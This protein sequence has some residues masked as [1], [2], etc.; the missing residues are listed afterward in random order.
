[1]IRQARIRAIGGKVLAVSVLATGF[2]IGVA[3]QA[4]V[5]SGGVSLYVAS[6]GSGSS[7]TSTAPCGSIGA[8]LAVATPGSTIH[9]G[10]GT[11]TEQDQ[12]TVSNVKI[13]GAGP[14]KTIIQP[15]SSGLVS[16]TDTDSGNPQF[17]T[18]DVAPGT[19]GVTLEKLGVDDANAISF[20][21]SDGDGCAQDPVGIYYHDA[22]GTIDD[23]AVTGVD[24][25]ADLAGCQGG[26]GIYVA[27]NS[28]STSTVTMKKVSEPTATGASFS[29][30][31]LPAY[32]KNGITCDDPGTTC[33]ITK[34]TVEGMGPTGVIAQNGIQVFGASATVEKNKVSG[35]TYTLGGNGN[36]ATG[37]LVLNAGT[38][39]VSQNQAFSSDI[40]IYG[41]LVPSYGLMPPTIGAWSFAGNAAT[42]ATDTGFP[43]SRLYGEGIEID[44]TTNNVT[45]SG[46][47]AE[48]NNYSGIMLL[49]ATGAVVSNNTVEDNYVGL[50]LGAPGSAI[51]PSTDNTV[52]GNTIESNYTFGVL[53][54]GKYD[55]GAPLSTGANSGAASDNTFGGNTWSGNSVAQAADFS[56]S[57]GSSPAPITNTWGSPTADSCE[58]TAGGDPTGLGSAYY[59]C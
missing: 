45:V 31:K 39:T 15:P 13:K 22:S 30:P 8:A 43:S 59:A 44:S 14:T 10:A 32:D 28:G 55:P 33:T 24:M 48:G 49:G 50:Y 2:G 36:Q 11:Y 58:P 1:M 7:C 9:V 41:G 47:T 34:S 52:T 25:P 4:A 40:D 27:S 38:V 51:T 16:D 5:A 17:Y 29:G 57:N 26:Q 3:A 35:D 23:V 18:V 42:S 20:F 56:G 12:I 53:V 21:G 6:G 37:I 54:D 19:T 46:N